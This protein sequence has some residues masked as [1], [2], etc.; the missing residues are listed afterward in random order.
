MLKATLPQPCLQSQSNCAASSKANQNPHS[1]KKLKPDSAEACVCLG[2]QQGKKIESHQRWQLVGKSCPSEP[3]EEEMKKS[4]ENFLQETW[5]TTGNMLQ[6][7]RDGSELVSDSGCFVTKGFPRAASGLPHSG[8][9]NQ[10]DQSQEWKV[11]KVKRVLI[12]PVGEP[13][14]ANISRSASLSEKELKEAKARSQ[15]IAAQ[16]TTPPNTNSKGVLLFHR[17]KQRVNAFTETPQTRREQAA[18]EGS[19]TAIHHTISSHGKEHPLKQTLRDN[20][21]LIGLSCIKDSGF[22]GQK[23]SMEKYEENL[24]IDRSL[25]KTEGLQSNNIK[26]EEILST[27]NTISSEEIPAEDFQQIPLS[28]Y[29]KQNTETASANGMHELITNELEK[30][31]VI[32]QAP[33]MDTVENIPPIVDDEPVTDR[34]NNSSILNKDPYIL[35]MDREN[36]FLD[37]VP[38]FPHIDTENNNNIPDKEPCI[39]VIDRD[40][41]NVVVEKTL[42]EPVIDRKENG[43]IFSKEEDVLIIE[44]KNILPTANIEEPLLVTEK[45]PNETVTHNNKQY[46]EVRLT[47]SKPMPVKNRTARPFGTQS[48]AASQSQSL[49]LTQSL[50]VTHTPAEKS[51]VVELPPP[52]TYAET[53]SSPPPVTR[54]RSPPAY[55]ALYPSEEQKAPIPQEPRY[56]ENR[57]GP[58]PGENREVPSTKTGILEESVARRANKKSMFTFVEKPKVA[59]N[60]DLLNLV[61]R[62]DNWRRQKEQ[63]GAIPE[64]EPFAL[65]AEA[66]N[67]LPVTIPTDGPT[68]A[69]GDAAPEWSSCLRS[70][71]IQPKPKIKSNQN[72][73]EARGKGAELFARR[74]SRMQKYV[75][76]SSS[77]HPDNI[78][79]PSPTMSLPPSWKYVSETHLSPMAFQPPPK[80]PV[81]SPR[82]P[83]VPLYNS[84]MTESEISKKEL[85]IS[86]QQPYQL[87]SSLFILSPAKDPVRALP[88]AAPPPKPVVPESGY[89]RQASCPTSALLP[90][91]I[92]HPPAQSSPGRPLP[93]NFAPSAGTLLAPQNIRTAAG[94]PLEASFEYPSRILSPRAKAIFQAPRPSYSTKDAGIEPQERRVSL[95]ASPTWTPRLWRQP[96]SLDGWVS[97]AQTPE[98]E[99]GL[100]EAF[101]AVSVMTPPP[102]PPPPMS[103]SWSER[104]LSPFRQE[105]D[106]KSNRQMQVLLA[107]NIIN[108]A[109]RKSSSPKAPGIDS[110]RPFTPP[111]TSISASDGSP[112]NMGNRSPSP[113]Q[114][115]SPRRMDGYRCVS[116]PITTAPS[117][118]SASSNNSPRLLGSQSP[119]YKSPL[120]SPKA[121]RMNGNKYFTLPAS[122]G[123]P[124]MNVTSSNGP[125]TMG[126]HSVAHRDPVQSPKTT[127]MDSHRIFTP[128]ASTTRKPSCTSPK[129]LGTVS[130]TIKSPLQSPIVGTHSPVKRYT[131]MSPTNSDV[132][133]DSEDSGIKSPSIRS[134][135]I[136]PRGWNG[137]LRLKRGS[138]PAEASCTS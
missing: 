69:P 50:V 99:E 1:S 30:A 120:Q 72:L 12:S 121:G 61:Q 58:L 117:H 2:R 80:S 81:R 118:V 91:P 26:S 43:E 31:N 22:W 15:R 113:M 63:R 134:F 19:P 21:D 133:L 109:R 38:Y 115:P 8:L 51:N 88:K 96:S 4:R 90:S 116:V 36:N 13:R 94:A 95:P 41:N 37:K 40:N 108:A 3:K 131:S 9:S 55:S 101:R 18:A 110:F 48:L 84:S 65:G 107:R 123:S 87:Q 7:K 85:E 82:T 102:L 62:S 27:M 57:P 104:S 39:P 79:S 44:N 70:P 76:E 24:A 93:A 60:P 100:T 10:G 25:E 71:K 138:L 127:I 64:D 14:K 124:L 34:E 52:P 73:T 66:S 33:V 106:P 11:V 46:C 114:S 86:K 5:R 125:R 67:F 16:L 35:H 130:P 28:V 137:S 97:P 53:F 68:Q 17:R 132:S 45:Q 126:N 6:F 112:K 77:H 56:E 29:L 47:L 129:D 49:A 75:I 54:V 78:R 105:T 135:N 83:P 136:C 111:A 20:R 92:L 103:P 98:P 122:T 42:S 119:T 89:M 23:S 74:Q 128:P 32:E 59:P